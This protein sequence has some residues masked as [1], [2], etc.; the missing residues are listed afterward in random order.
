MKMNAFSIILTNA[1]KQKS[2][3]KRERERVSSFVFF[4]Q[5]TR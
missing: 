3:E 5:Q 2:K 1:N 4:N